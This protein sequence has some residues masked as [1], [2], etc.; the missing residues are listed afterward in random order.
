M[1]H[2]KKGRKLGTDA[3]HRKAMLRSLAIALFTNERI[4]TTEAKA[5]EVRSLV[6][7]IITLA[8]RGDV[9]ARRQVLGEIGDRDLVP[10]HLRHQFHRYT[11]GD[12]LNDA[13]TEDVDV[14]AHLSR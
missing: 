8:K 12:R 6:E 9:H 3:S 7:K 14:K 10:E 1:R 13:L 5:K 2:L 4:K 11:I